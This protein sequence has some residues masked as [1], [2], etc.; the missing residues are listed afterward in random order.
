MR[1]GPFGAVPE[2]EDQLADLRWHWDTAYEISRTGEKWTA[3]FLAGTNIL[4]ASSADDLRRLIR[5]DFLFRKSAG[6]LEDAPP[7]E[8]ERELGVG[9]ARCG[10]YVTGE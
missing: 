3:R 5:A 1:T 8:S 2:E 10:G 9:S 4:T 6:T 7:A